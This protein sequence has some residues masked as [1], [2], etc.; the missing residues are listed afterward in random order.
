MPV[1]EGLRRL[2]MIG[3]HKNRVAVRQAHYEIADLLA[4]AAQ[5]C[6]RLAKIRLRMTRGMDKRHEALLQGPT[7][8]AHIIPHRRVA[9][10]EAPFLAEPFVNPSDRMALLLRL[11]FV[12]QQDRVHKICVRIHL[13]PGTLLAQPITR[14][15]AELRH[16]CDCAAIKTENARRLRLAH[17]VAQN[18]AADP[19]INFHVV[20]PRLKANLPLQGQ[21]SCGFLN[22]PRQDNPGA[23]A[24]GFTGALYTF[25][26]SS[27]S[28]SFE[29]TSP[30]SRSPSNSSTS[31]LS[32]A[33]R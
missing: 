22:R 32:M 24:V 10:L 6:R 26:R 18:R 21:L 4:D 16:L 1:A 14:W 33:M 13:R 15:F 7:P 2:G 3:L 31:F 12:L 5:H 8:G 19:S 27:K 11:V 20:H 17:P 28:P 9:A 29:K 30:G 23:S 25:F